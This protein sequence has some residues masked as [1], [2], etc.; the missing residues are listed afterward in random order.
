MCDSRLSIKA[1]GLIAFLYSLVQAGNR[2]FPHRSTICIFLGLSKDS[3]YKALNQLIDYN[4]LTVRQRHTKSGRFTVNDYILN[5][6][7]TKTPCSDFCDNN[8]ITSI[9]SSNNIS[10]SNL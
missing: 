4:Y 6:N 7:P 2:A 9:N 10:T 3:Y 5:S 1:K 8:N